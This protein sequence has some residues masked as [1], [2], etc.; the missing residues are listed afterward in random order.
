MVSA[1]AHAPPLRARPCGW[2]APDAPA[3]VHA[4]AMDP[5]L[6][7]RVAGQSGL[8]TRQQALDGGFT[9]RA[10]RWRLSRGRWLQMH[11]GVYL[12]E[13]GRREWEVRAVAAL[14]HVGA[15]S[16]LCGPSA[17]H[18]WGLVPTAPD[19]VHVVVPATHRG[20][21]RDGITVVRSRQLAARVHPTAWPHR[22]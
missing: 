5:L 19:A 9:D 7:A 15:P 22:T 3:V 6:R 16:A 17:G 14:L 2:G 18:A 20:G 8:I 21:D 1:S 12:T 13:P 10:V 11:P 4:P